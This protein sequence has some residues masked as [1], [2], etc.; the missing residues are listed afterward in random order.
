MIISVAKEA[1]ARNGQWNP[2]IAV[3]AELKLDQRVREGV[4]SSRIV[5]RILKDLCG[6]ETVSRWLMCAPRSWP[7]RTIG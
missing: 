7:A 3:D 2:P 1:L 6:L 4:M 5:P